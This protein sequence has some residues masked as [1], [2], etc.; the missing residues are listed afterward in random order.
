MYHIA[1]SVEE[2]DFKPVLNLL[3]SYC[4]RSFRAQ[5]G[6]IAGIFDDGNVAWSIKQDF[7][8]VKIGISRYQGIAMGLSAIAKSGEILVDQDTIS[9]L[10]ESFEFAS[11]GLINI[12]GMKAQLMV[13]Q[14]ENLMHPS[15]I[16]KREAKEFPYIKREHEENIL[17]EALSATNLVQIIGRDGIG[18]T[19]FLKRFAE[20]SEREV[21]FIPIWNY[22]PVVPFAP[23][24]TLI[25]SLIGI[26][27]DTTI[28][29]A[30]DLLNNRLKDLKV[31]DFVSSYYSFLEF[32]R[33]TEEETLMTKLNLPKRFEILKNSIVELII[34]ANARKK[35]LIIFDD[36]QFAD[37]SSLDL[38]MQ[39][40]SAIVD[41]DIK[42]I[43]TSEYP[44]DLEQKTRNVEL[45]L[46]NPSAQHELIDLFGVEGIAPGPTLPLQLNLYLT[47]V[48][49]ERD[50]ALYQEFQG[51]SGIHST[52][53]KEI[54]WLINRW[55]DH[56]SDQA[57]E[58][59][60]NAA[61]IGVQFSESELKYLLPK[62]RNDEVIPELIENN[63]ISS[64]DGYQFRH[65]LVREAIYEENANRAKIHSRLSEYYE[66]RNDPIRTVFHLIHAEKPDQ[67]V[68]VYLDA[69][70]AALEKNAWRTAIDYYLEAKDIIRQLMESKKDVDVEI[71][72]SINE[73]IG[74]I[75]RELGD[76]EN[77]LKFYKSVL[78]SYR[79]ILK[80]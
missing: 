56:L 54:S 75:Y 7:P 73:R 33:I 48:D 49:V 50:Y 52:P 4:G 10:M 55:L 45:G 3:K 36:L 68:K 6:I 31:R 78:D 67:A 43:Y 16:K 9:P 28:A 1:L 69:A 37:G 15:E 30:Q 29:E 74:D 57:R 23:I 40:L 32:L 61:V 72:I 59:V 11:L 79:D 8:K 5:P 63:I 24:E 34:K 47:L 13:Y 19:S 20:E 38:L 26:K 25:R 12:E 70:Q 42:I 77:A 64:N 14:V 17:K 65:R 71:I 39:M 44:I 18:K 2:H 51:K 46:L 76:E 66:K 22:P 62:K 53:F 41:S 60:M 35:L 58:L 27:I 80:E 21:H